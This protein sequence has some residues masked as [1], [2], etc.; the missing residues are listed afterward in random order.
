VDDFDPRRAS[1]DYNAA[2]RNGG[3]ARTKG[4]GLDLA[5]LKA[6]FE[7]LK[8][9]GMSHRP[10]TLVCQTIP[11]LSG[12]REGER[13]DRPRAG[14]TPY[15]RAIQNGTRTVTVNGRTAIARR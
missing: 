5:F 13:S 14:A 12:G 9:F 11:S 7:T 4:Q 3:S 1:T 6:A 2:A 10:Q 8:N 15:D